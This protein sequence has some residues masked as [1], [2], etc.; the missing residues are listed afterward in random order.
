PPSSRLFP[1]TTLFRSVYNGSDVSVSWLHRNAFRG[2][3][4]FRFSVFGGYEV[5][6]GGNVNL[7]SSFYRYGAEPSLTFPKIVA[8]F[9]LSTGRDRKSTRL[10]SS[11]VKI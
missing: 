11:H 3:E 10:N 4:Q 5:Q 2:A 7:N 8:P 9:N 6:T 1:Y